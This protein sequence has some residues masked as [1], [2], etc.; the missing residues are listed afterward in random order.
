MWVLLLIVITLL[1]VLISYCKVQPF[2]S[3]LF[4]SKITGLVYGLKTK[5]VVEAVQNEIGSTLG[6][7]LP[8]I[9]L[10]AIIGKIIAKTNA[11]IYL[12]KE[13]GCKWK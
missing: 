1:V 11:E 9:L 8:I 13:N 5:L 7:I 12:I 4:V 10:G 3:F 6:S 2:L